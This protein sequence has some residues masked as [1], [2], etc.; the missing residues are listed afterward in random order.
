MSCDRAGIGLPG[1][2]FFFCWLDR[3]RFVS[4]INL[5]IAQSFARRSEGSS[6]Q[7]WPGP[8]TKLKV[9]TGTTLLE[10]MICTY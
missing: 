10:T 7:L 1:P 3:L 9:S 8:L 2:C 6:G 4:A 5:E